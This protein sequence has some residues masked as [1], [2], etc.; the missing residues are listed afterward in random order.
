M[1]AAT[2]KFMVDEQ[3]KAEAENAAAYPI[4]LMTFGTRPL[5][6]LGIC[7]MCKIRFGMVPAC[8]WYGK[9]MITGWCP[10][11][12]AQ[13]EKVVA[14]PQYNSPQYHIL[15]LK[16]MCMRCGGRYVIKASEH[17]THVS[18]ALCPSCMSWN[19]EQ[20]RLKAAGLLP[21][22][23]RLRSR[24]TSPITLPTKA[25]RGGGSESDE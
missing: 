25:Q 6:L 13:M 21:L 9:C 15:L 17:A 20:Q 7:M 16:I 22:P 11:C 2:H 8:K 4:D 3:A 23:R 10:A 5:M 1:Q 19:A 18:V 12:L 14:H 24:A